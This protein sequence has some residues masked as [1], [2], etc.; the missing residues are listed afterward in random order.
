LQ[1]ALLILEQVPAQFVISAAP[2]VNKTHIEQV[3][4][5]VLHGH[6]RADCFRIAEAESR[7]ILANTDFALVK[8]GTSTLEAALVGTPFVIVYKISALSWNLADPFIKTPFR[9]LVNLIAGE[10]VVPEL[11]QH[12]FTAE[13]VV[14]RLK[15]ILPDGPVRDRMLQ[16]L[17][18][19]KARLRAPQADF[20]AVHPADR[21]AGII[22]ELLAKR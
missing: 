14:V 21:A 16:R 17:A 19:V 3:V 5:S 18:H 11:V 15:E 22:L 20:G 2:T 1:A 12:D 9:G 7:D 10:E 13:R 8:S 4:S 6:P